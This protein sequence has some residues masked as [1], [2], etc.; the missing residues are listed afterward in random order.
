MAYYHSIFTIAGDFDGDH[1]VD[2][3]IADNHN[4]NIR[5][6]LGDG[7][8]RFVNQTVCLTSL[9]P[10]FVMTGDFSNDNKIGIAVTNL[11]FYLAMEQNES[12]NQQIMSQVSSSGLNVMIPYTYMYKY[13]PGTVTSATVTIRVSRANGIRL[14]KIYLSTFNNVESS[15]TAVDCSNTAVGTNNVSAKV[16]TFYTAMDNNRLQDIN[17]NCANMEDYM[18]LYDKIKGSV[19]Q[20]SDMYRYNWFW[21]EDFTG[22]EN[23]VH[24]DYSNLEAGLDLY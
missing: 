14:Q 16:L 12:I 10:C 23:K 7:D 11:I 19:I 4:D 6:L 21:L 2:I 20:S 3:A 22:A 13:N 8:G 17:V 15:N 9:N 24:D 18:M 1:N 5:V